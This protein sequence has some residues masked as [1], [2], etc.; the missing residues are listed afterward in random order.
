[1]FLSTRSLVT[2]LVAASMLAAPIAAGTTLL[3]CEHKDFGGKCIEEYWSTSGECKNVPKDM[4]DKLSSIA[5]WGGSCQFFRNSGC[6]TAL[7]KSPHPP[8]NNPNVQTTSWGDLTSSII[9]YFSS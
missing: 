4:N 6:R 7:Y 5:V 1:M 9:C 3:Y 8:Y 2:S